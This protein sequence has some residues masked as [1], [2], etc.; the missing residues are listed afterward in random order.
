M[1]LA[2]VAH[3]AGQRR[4]PEPAGRWQPPVPRIL[5]SIGTISEPA[6]IPGPIGA[7]RGDRSNRAR[8]SESDGDFGAAQ[9]IVCGLGLPSEADQ[10]DELQAE[11]R[12]LRAMRPRP[13]LRLGP[14]APGVSP[15]FATRVSINLRNHNKLDKDLSL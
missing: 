3:R 14:E 1:V 10:S 7:R 13:L 15:I 4:L 11:T 9:V 8:A 5:S 12:Q 2:G 6:A